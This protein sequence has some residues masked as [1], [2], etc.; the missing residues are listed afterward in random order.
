ML[1]QTFVDLM[2]LPVFVPIILRLDHLNLDHSRAQ[3]YIIQG[4]SKVF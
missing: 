2:T 4:L 1:M 3:K